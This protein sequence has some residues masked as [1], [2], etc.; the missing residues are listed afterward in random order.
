MINLSYKFAQNSSSLEISGM[1]DVSNGD[2]TT[3]I[4]ILSS[5]SLKIIGSPLLEGEKVHLD[6]LMQVVL[7]YSRSYISGIRK[8]FVSEKNI[9][10][11]SPSG[12]NHKLLLKSTRKGVKPL[13]IFLD[14][15][16]L[17]DL[18]QCLDLLRFDSRLSIKWDIYID[19]PFTKR[20]IINN[21][22]KV[23]KNFNLLYAFIIFTLSSSLLLL[24]PINNNYEPEQGR[25]SSSSLTEQI[26]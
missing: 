10:S 16:E 3:T 15:S 26:N 25:K 23:K 14:D 4:G 18:T 9:V 13:E 24:I 2:S 7:Q 8:T 5:W 6:N 11:I 12:N 17:S 19:R 1:P 21:S 20:F 22:N